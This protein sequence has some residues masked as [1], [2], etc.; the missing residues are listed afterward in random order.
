MKKVSIIIPVFNVDK[1]RFKKTL[2]SLVAQTNK[3][4]EVCISDGGMGHKV[5]D[6]IDVYKRKLNIRYVA[7]KKK[8]GISENTNA[9][10]GLASAEYVGFLDHD[11]LL[12]ASAVQDSIV[13]LEEGGYDAVYS[14]EDIVTESGKV[15]NKLFKP[16]FSPDLLYAQNYI[17]HF[18]V[19]KKEI[20]DKVGKFSSKYDGAQDYDFVLRVM[21]QTKKFGHIDKILYHWLATED[22]TSTNSD[23][24]PYA[25]TAG[26]K[27]LDAHLKR[28]Y[29]KQAEAVETD[30]LF[31]YQPRY[32]NLKN[33]KID[34]IIPMRDKWILSD[35]CI[36]SILNKTAYRNYQIT[37]ID[38]G[39]QERQTKT[40]L[41]TIVEK[42]NRI[43]VLAA[44]FEFNWSKLQN[45][46]IQ[47]SDAD[48]FVFLNN[49]TIIVDEDWLE[50]LGEQAI[51]PSAGVV[52]PLLLYDD[53]TI[54]HAGVVVGL[55]GYADHI[56][57]GAPAVH[58]GVNFIS[59][60]V[61][62]DV[63]AVT[64]ACMVISRETLDK[65]GLFDEKF[66][67]CGSDV[68]ICIRAY[69]MGLY[70]I[71]TPNTRLV[72]LE[73]KS[74]SSE[75]PEV[76]FRLSRITYQKYWD[77]GDPFYNNNLNYNFV[78]PFEAPKGYNK[79]KKTKL[80]KSIKRSAIVRKTYSGLRRT[81]KDNKVVRTIYR[82]VR[83]SGEMIINSENRHEKVRLGDYRVTEIRD[84]E[85]IK[86]QPVSEKIRINLLIPSLNPEHVFGG[87]ATAVKFF[88]QFS[89]EQFD[90]RI[91]IVDM[92]L[93]RRALT[94]K[95]AN[96]TVVKSDA[97]TAEALQVTEIP[98]TK[99]LTVTKNDVFI[100]T[101]WWTAYSIAPLI[102]W[103]KSEYKLK[104]ARPLV[105]LIQDFEPGFY[106]WS[107]R[108]AMAE[109]T[110]RLGVPTI[111]VFNSAELR[112]FF[113]RKKYQFM[114]EYSF[115]PILND[116]LKQHLLNDENVSRKKQIIVY[117]RPNTPRNAFEI[118][119]DSLRK[120][121][122]DRDDA[123]EWKFI[124]MGE[125]HADVV[126]KGKAH[127]VSV[128]KLTLDGYAKVMEESYLGIS[129]MVSPHPSYPPLEMS[130]F[131][132]RVI[133]NQYDNKDLGKFNN[134]IISVNGCDPETIA[135]TLKEYI[136]NFDRYAKTAKKCINKEYTEAADQFEPIV[137]SI[138]KII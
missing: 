137:K 24:K 125:D 43:R 8:L 53:E 131:G 114:K 41:K 79:S 104:E 132:V 62:R 71:Y 14:D 126:I 127:L 21:E 23:A 86:A 96:Y 70:N 98:E 118:V 88:N 25:Q 58:A 15:L 1:E 39:S 130:S 81:L 64:G 80:K 54:Q 18:F 128:G 133:T 94:E 50:I 120:T 119:V 138:A 28:V 42:N 9:A 113:K 74:R 5:D 87:I 108:Y 19:V 101:A 57:K 124:S 26:L 102:N 29:G 2:D 109:K 78:I 27:A 84:I 111:A 22:S 77:N 75:V 107:S 46:G 100:A 89:E 105:Y 136:D 69:E 55:G 16:D 10:L 44:D 65:I 36:S 115:D 99:K 83:H 63:L 73:S 34:I 31:V 67:I 30:N 90:K 68:E 123:D 6:V 52:G 72:H 35:T 110:Y 37:I 121:F 11:D 12:V 112:D 59:P 103:Q 56:Y 20:V 61:Q 45:F 134:N 91:V 122:K 48:I 7:S 82:K 32:H 47:H 117:G 51:R 85:P 66:L 93:K 106:N 38:N 60:M 116:K 13:K 135:N 76:D 33:Q 49:D 3:D 92:P 40:W 129:L 97:E 95:F 4:F 17:C